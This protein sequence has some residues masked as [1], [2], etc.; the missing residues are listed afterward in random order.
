MSPK[1]QVALDEFLEENLRKGYI[2][3]SKSPAAAPVF[4]I[5]KKDGTLRLVVDYR[6]LNEIT[7]KNRYPS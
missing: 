3:Q 4:F 6:K 7:V 2:R 5:K 1:E